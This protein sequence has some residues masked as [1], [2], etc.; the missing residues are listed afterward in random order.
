MEHE[1]PNQ[2][3]DTVCR[4][5]LDLIKEQSIEDDSLLHCMAAA[6]ALSAFG[7]EAKVE[8][9]DIMMKDDS[10]SNIQF[11]FLYVNELARDLAGNVDTDDTIV[12]LAQAHLRHLEE[13]YDFVGHEVDFVP[14]VGKLKSEVLERWDDFPSKCDHLA[15]QIIARTNGAPEPLPLPPDLPGTTRGGALS[16][17]HYSNAGLKCI[18]DEDFDGV[19]NLVKKW[20]GDS[21]LDRP[22]NFP[23]VLAMWVAGHPWFEKR[24]CEGEV[25]NLMQFLKDNGADFQK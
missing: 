18:E 2:L 16:R 3:I 12:S 20:R 8:W 14:L 4:H 5:A 6:K 1:S 15:N 25:V 7:I 10:F 24:G 19:R 23:T 13:M 17:T 21:D 11:A 9:A 22:A